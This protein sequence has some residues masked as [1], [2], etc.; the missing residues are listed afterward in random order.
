MTKILPIAGYNRFYCWV[1]FFDDNM[2]LLKV[3]LI[4][5]KNDI[6]PKF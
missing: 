6:F 3:I 1:T 4:I 2:Q 5:N